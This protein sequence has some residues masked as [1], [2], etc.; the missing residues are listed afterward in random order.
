MSQSS[1]AVGK[2]HALVMLPKRRWLNPRHL[3]GRITPAKA[4]L[5]LVPLALIALWQLASLSTPEFVL[6]SPTRVLLQT[7]RLLF[8]PVLITH[9]YISLARV[10]AAVVLS[11]LLGG[12]VVVAARYLPIVKELVTHLVIPFF[13]SFPSLG[14]AIL[15]IYWLGISES[16]VVF[17]EV[18]ILLPFAMINLWEGLKNLDEEIMEMSLS[19]TRRRWGI[20]RLI[21]LPLLFPYVLAS[22]RISYGVGWKVSLIAELFGTS[23]GLGFLLN[24]SRLYFESSLLFA[25]IA[26]I[27]FL[28]FVVDKL[29]FDRVERRFTKFRA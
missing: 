16:S 22:V 6:P 28:V 25:T 11:L 29:V 20:L 3:A 7:V 4:V 13:N 5:Y 18:V 8:D 10:L 2:P 21:V 19:F 27:L 17:V 12:G 23:T 9:T 24:Y 1:P 14:W 15:A 26:T